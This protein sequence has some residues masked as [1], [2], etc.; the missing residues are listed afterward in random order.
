MPEN[1]PNRPTTLMDRFAAATEVPRVHG[2]RVILQVD[3]IRDHKGCR[4]DLFQNGK[5]S[6]VAMIVAVQEDA[7]IEGT[8]C[9]MLRGATTN[10]ALPAN[11]HSGRTSDQSILR[12]TSDATPLPGNDDRRSSAVRWRRRAR[13]LAIRLGRHDAMPVVRARRRTSD[14]RSSYCAALRRIACRPESKFL[15]PP[16]RFVRTLAET[17]SPRNERW[18]LPS[19]LRRRRNLIQPGAGCF[20]FDCRDHTTPPDGQSLS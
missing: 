8:P 2:G 11:P 1:T 19:A 10:A 16:K 6:V 9:V 13:E 18:P 4:H 12:S 7:P 14:D 5:V 3:P 17:T 20:P 15:A